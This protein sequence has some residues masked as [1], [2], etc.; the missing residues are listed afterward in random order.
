LPEAHISAVGQ[1][2]DALGGISRAQHKGTKIPRPCKSVRPRQETRPPAPCPKLLHAIPR[3]GQSPS[4]CGAGLA[5]QALRFFNG[6]VR[7]RDAP[8]PPPKAKRNR[9]ENPQ[10]YDSNP[11]LHASGFPQPGTCPDD[12]RRSEMVVHEPR[13]RNAGKYGRWVGH[14]LRPLCLKVSV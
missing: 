8:P 6:F 5:F 10:G 9:M 12:I 2:C 14:C 11:A 13:G 3:P 1:T 4:K 7:A